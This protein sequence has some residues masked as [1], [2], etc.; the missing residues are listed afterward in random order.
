MSFPSLGHLNTSLLLVVFV[1]GGWG[2]EYSLKG[3]DHWQR[4][5]S[6]KPCLLLIC[7]LQDVNSQLPIPAAMAPLL[8]SD[9][10]PL[11]S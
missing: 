10:Y 11:D 7:S 2:D 5:Q 9:S 1:G 3:V 6:K 8:L 4:L